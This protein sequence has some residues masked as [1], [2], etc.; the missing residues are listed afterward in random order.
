MNLVNGEDYVLLWQDFTCWMYV[1]VVV[2]LGS[3]DKRKS[4]KELMLISN[5]V[6]C[7]IMIVVW[8]E[9]TLV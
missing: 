8:C 6:Q 5:F 4:M 2:Y 3:A 7:V 1:I 9:L